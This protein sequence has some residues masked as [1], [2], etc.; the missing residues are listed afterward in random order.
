[1]STSFIQHLIREMEEILEDFSE[2]YRNRDRDMRSII[3]E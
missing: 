3:T 2:Q 1:M